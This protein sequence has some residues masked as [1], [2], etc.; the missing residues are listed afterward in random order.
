MFKDPTQLVGQIV[1]GYRLHQVLGQG[2]SA[3]VFRGE[4]VASPGIFRA[5]KVIRPELAASVEFTKR[6]QMESRTLNDL[7]HPHIVRFYSAQRDDKHGVLMMDIELLDGETLA[8]RMKRDAPLAV[9]DVLTWVEQAARGVGAA[10]KMGVLHR[11]LKPD[12][13]FLTKSGV[14]VLDFG[15]AKAVEDAE[16]TS[17]LTKEGHV[18][19]TAA[20]MA[21]EVWRGDEPSAK[22]DV[23]ALGMTMAEL[24]LGR[25]P[26]IGPD[27]KWP[28][29]HQLMYRHIEGELPRVREKRDDVSDAVATVM[30]R[31]LARAESARFADANAMADALA[32]VR[33]GAKAPVPEPLTTDRALPQASTGREDGPVATAFAMP[34]LGGKVEPGSPSD[35]KVVT[36]NV[37]VR[38]SKKGL[39][40][41]FGVAAVGI[42]VLVAVLAGGGG[43]AAT[44]VAKAGAKGP[45]AADAAGASAAVVQ[46]VVAA[47]ERTDVVEGTGEVQA[48]AEVA[49]NK[50]VLV[51][52]PRGRDPVYLGLSKELGRGQA[53]G[54]R[55]S[56][57]VLA[58]T[59]P[60]EVMQHEVTWDELDL[61][62][63]ENAGRAFM[64]P[65]FA[66]AALTDKA[67]VGKRPGGNHPATG[68]PWEVAY[69][70]CRALGG[71]LPT[72]EQWEYAARG[73]E[74]RPYAWGSNLPDL[75]RV[76]A[77]QGKGATPGP[78][79]SSDQDVT[80]APAGESIFDLMGNAQEW[81]SDLWREGTPGQDETWV[82]DGATS[83]RAVRGLPLDQAPPSPM[84]AEG[85]AYRDALC[86]TGPCVEGA[87][88]AYKFVGFRCVRAA[89]RR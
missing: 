56:R 82:Q 48:E 10:H 67:M 31:A 46:P 76:A 55:P 9:A 80:P 13:L 52:P 89:A 38:R 73:E 81:T 68:V 30:N 5:I 64:R 11:D 23:Y 79:M 12:N 88:D 3:M 43:P 39:F 16:R 84:P 75:M 72:E 44:P 37:R 74:K 61:W 59:A 28:T 70:Y 2:A 26:F 20:Y 21:P 86:A 34:V 54:F 85:A 33:G 6:F 65:S 58:P 8:E 53:S 17:A 50:W 77:Y 42:G 66:V 40:I 41:G 45:T 29:N 4:S 27:G 7:V 14:K 15:I 57:K 36:E 25:H 78:V 62:L 83:F 19:G 24:L 69:A 1:A 49:L 32:A 47:V 51:T 63:L 60:F 35:P 71:A 87:R 22:S 18:A